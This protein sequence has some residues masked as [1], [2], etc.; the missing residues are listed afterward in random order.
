MD[1]F[2]IAWEACQVHFLNAFSDLGHDDISVCHLV[3]FAS[4][5]YLEHQLCTLSDA[6]L[7]KCPLVQHPSLSFRVVCG[8]YL[9]DSRIIC[10][11]HGFLFLTPFFVVS[12]AS[13]QEE[14]QL[15]LFKNS[16]KE[17]L[18]ADRVTIKP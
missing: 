6:S 17:N 7:A 18:F 10:K 12:V 3:R 2:Q 13:C 8:S 4:I 15:A 14:F 1:V 9:D 16:K 5:T 11:N